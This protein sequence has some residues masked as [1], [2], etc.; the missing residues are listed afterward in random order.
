MLRKPMPVAAVVIFVA[1]MGVRSY[2][3]HV[4]LVANSPLAELDYRDD[5]GMACFC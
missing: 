3:S 4:L 5:H 1:I 2:A